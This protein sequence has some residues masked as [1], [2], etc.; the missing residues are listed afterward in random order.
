VVT[1]QDVAHGDRVE[2][3]PQI[4]QGTLD[5]AIAPGWILLGHAD[6]ELLHLL[7]NT[8]SAMLTTLHTPVKLLGDQSRVPMQER[9]RRDDRGDLFEALATERMGQ[10]GE[11]AAFGIG[12][13]QS[14]SVEVSFED[15]VFL[16]QIGNR[17]YP[18]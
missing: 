12:Q 9:V 10:C 3:M 16:L 5:T 6:D 8:G 4:C 15:A 1:A 17:A 18:D 13:A 14:A 2:M 11:A 7:G